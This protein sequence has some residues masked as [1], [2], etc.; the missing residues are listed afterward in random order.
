MKSTLYITDLDGTLL[1]SDAQLTAFASDTLNAMIAGGLAFTV[2]TARTPVSAGK[3]L[4]GLTPGAPVVSL[5]GAVVEDVKQKSYVRI[6]YFAPETVDA[7]I[8]LLKSLDV[9]CFMFAMADGQ[10]ATY[11]ESFGQKPPLG[12]AEERIAKYYM[13]Y[14]HTEGFAGAPPDR[15]IYFSLLDEY[16]RLRPIHDELAARPDL[17]LTLYKDTY[18]SRGWFLEIFGAGASKRNAVNYL[19]EAYGYGRVVCFGDNLNDLPMFEAADVRVAVKN[20]KPEVKAAADYIC[21]SNDDDGV[22]KW[23]W[24]NRLNL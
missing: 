23:I 4:A 12:I 11:H 24:E 22:V 13:T 7:I 18:T 21:G 14:R 20:A 9:T 6:C 8:G 3:I 2:A 16:D 17:S 5:N 15:I 19:R 10:L 1:N